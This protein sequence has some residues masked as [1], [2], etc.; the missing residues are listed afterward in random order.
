MELIS[1][2]S[3][4]CNI[5]VCSYP[6]PFTDNKTIKN[7]MNTSSGSTPFTRSSYGKVNCSLVDNDE[8]NN[9]ITTRTTIMIIRKKD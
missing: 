5:D 9:T 6:T 4:Q 1:K 3:D 7:S 2:N 8:H